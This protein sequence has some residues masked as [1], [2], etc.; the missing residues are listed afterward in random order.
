MKSDLSFLKDSQFSRFQDTDIKKASQV[1]V[2]GSDE[3]KI[4]ANIN[5]NAMGEKIA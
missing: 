2:S 4:W 5:I 1:W 3:A